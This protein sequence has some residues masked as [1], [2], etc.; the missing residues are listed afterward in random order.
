MD[1]FGQNLSNLFVTVGQFLAPIAA[2]ASIVS[3][4]WQIKR[5][6][7]IEREALDIQDEVIDAAR[8]NELINIDRRHRKRVIA[9]LIEKTTHCED[10]TERYWIYKALG[11]IGGRKALKAIK[12]GLSDDS[13]FARE[14]AETALGN[15]RR[16]ME[17][18]Q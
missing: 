18:A 14:G 8:K 11:E 13:E 1:A 17:D 5:R 4:I 9:H 3:V 12:K 6:R 16:R 2:I 15:I 7:M 10:P